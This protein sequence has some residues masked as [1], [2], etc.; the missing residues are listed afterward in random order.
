MRY[1]EDV[2]KIYKVLNK[3]ENIRDLNLN[4]SVWN[5]LDNGSVICFYKYYNLCS[6]K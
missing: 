2:V 6:N 5:V 1:V 3:N 4:G